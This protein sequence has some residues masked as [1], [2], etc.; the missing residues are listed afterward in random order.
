MVGEGVEDFVVAAVT[1][2]FEDQMC[3]VAIRLV[4]AVVDSSNGE[5]GEMD[6]A[7]C[8]ERAANLGAGRVAEGRNLFAYAG[9]RRCRLDRA[10]DRDH[11]MLGRAAKR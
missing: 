10:D 7:A 5:A 2:Q 1:G 3:A 11:R 6:D 8:V 9:E 4:P